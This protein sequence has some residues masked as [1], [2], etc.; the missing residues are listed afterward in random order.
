MQADINS[1]LQGTFKLSALRPLQAEVVE[2]VLSGESALVLMP[3]GSGKSLTYQLPSQILGGLTLVLSPLKALMK[4][5]VDKLK[6]LGVRA[7]YINSDVTKNERDLRLRKLAQNKYKIFYV[8]PERFQKSDFLEV[9]AKQ[10]ISLL[11]VDE[12]HCISQWGHDFRPDYSKLD[13]IRK[14]LSSSP[15]V[16]ALTATAT[17]PVREDILK[18]LEIDKKN[19]FSLPVVRENL[20]VSVVDLYGIEN[21][22]KAAVDILREQVLSKSGGSHIIYFSLISTLQ[23]FSF[24]LQKMKINHEVYH[25]DMPEKQK[26]HAQENFL[27]GSSPIILATPAFGLGI[28]K[29]DVRTV[30]HAEIPGSLEAY[31]QEIGR[32]GRDGSPSKCVLL[33]DEDDVTTQMEFIKWSNPDGNF[34]KKILHIIAANPERV[35]QEGADFLREQMNFYNKRDFRVETALN[36]LR[37]W[38]LLEGWLATSENSI[39]DF[40]DDEIREAKLKRQNEKLLHMVRFVSS[41]ACRMQYI[42]SY[43]SEENHKP[44]GLCDRC[45]ENL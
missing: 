30:I 21:K 7:E 9:I 20:A 19:I 36:L 43:F 23:K 44:C 17:L 42:Y 45:S 41:E 37:S 11:V 25:G 4:D 13:K 40:I 10:N 34:I 27:S 31:F 18:T 24:E 3:T 35:R 33:Y 6:N 5:Q 15:P 32:A 28:D 8:T 39:E 14:R 22:V 16:L 1:I 12:A 38:G 26:R 29:A 2:H